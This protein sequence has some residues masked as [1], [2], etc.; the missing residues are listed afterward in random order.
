LA[1]VNVEC[2]A[3]LLFRFWQILDRASGA[4]ALCRNAGILPLKVIEEPVA[5]VKHEGAGSLDEVP[6][7]PNL[8]AFDQGAPL[9]LF[10]L[11]P[12]QFTPLV[13]FPTAQLH[14]DCRISQ[15]ERI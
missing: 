4:K 7:R 5:I 14:D 11:L 6:L 2:H 8:Q 1:S 12:V 3:L 15:D 9:G 10:P 13:N